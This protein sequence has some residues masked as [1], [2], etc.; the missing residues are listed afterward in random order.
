MCATAPKA[1]TET[2]KRTKTKTKNVS[3]AQIEANRRNAKE[4]CGPKSDEG[5]TWS[6]FNALKHGMT[7]QT[8]L[9]PGDDSKAFLGRLQYLQDDLQPRNSLEGVALERLAGDLWIGRIRA[10]LQ[11]IADADEA[12]APVRLAFETGT[13]GDRGRRYILSYERL[14]N[15]RIDTFLKVRKASASGELDLVALEKELGTEQFAD[16]KAAAGIPTTQ[17]TG[18]RPSLHGTDQAFLTQPG[19][20]SCPAPTC[21]SVRACDPTETDD[22]RSPLV[23]LTAD[24]LTTENA[25]QDATATCGRDPGRSRETLAHQPDANSDREISALSHLPEIPCG[26]DF[27][28]RNEAIIAADDQAGCGRRPDGNA[29]GSEAAASGA[30]VPSQ[31]NPIEPPSDASQCDDL[32]QSQRNHANDRPEERQNLENEESRTSLAACVANGPTSESLGTG[33]LD[34]GSN[35][36]NELASADEQDPRGDESKAPTAAVPPRMTAAAIAKLLVPM[37]QAALARL[38]DAE[39]NVRRAAMH[40]AKQGVL[41]P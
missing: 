14:V 34:N 32:A 39:I 28:L 19:G 8:V 29:P 3:T 16:L 37:D 27:I 20:E 30:C 40:S 5:K 11:Q 6:R 21:S 2:V 7:A 31:P 18:D 15:L 4:S 10:M 9:L 26:D 13:E 41:C 36:V 25:E 22:H 12:E 33:N 1:A 17:D 24:C 35:D 38:T 23:G